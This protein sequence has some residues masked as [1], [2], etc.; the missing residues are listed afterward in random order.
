VRSSSRP[1][2]IS[3]GPRG[4]AFLFDLARETSDAIWALTWD[5]PDADVPNTTRRLAEALTLARADR[6]QSASESEIIRSLSNA[7]LAVNVADAPT[8]L[9]VS[10]ASPRVMERLETL[11][12]ALASSP[13][14]AWFT[15][16]IASQQAVVVRGENIL[17]QPGGAEGLSPLQMWRDSQELGKSSSWSS[18]PEAA[19]LFISSRATKLLPATRLVLEED[20]LLGAPAFVTAME[21][22]AR[23]RS[24][25]SIDS[26][27]AWLDLVEAFPLDVT[28]TRA[29]TWSKVTGVNA[30][31][32]IPDWVAV[33]EE[34]DGVYL[35]VASYLEFAGTPMSTVAGQTLL[36]GWSADTTYW[37]T[38][39][40][41]LVEGSDRWDP[42]TS[43]LLA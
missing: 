4:R 9:E 28:P 35:P 20:G 24:V 1:F 13:N 31:W 40:I 41:Q 18:A 10:L 22:D 5:L 39:D 8:P 32:F 42:E 38:N 15:D 33:A 27:Q 16:A 11:A 3:Q 37:L 23:S 6:F 25:F 29:E 30:R 21:G 14:C 36:L 26:P 17:V 43:D 12:Q 7:A 2:L 34:F 19:V